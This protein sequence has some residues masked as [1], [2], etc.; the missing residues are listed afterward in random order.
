MIESRFVSVEI[1]TREDARF[2]HRPVHLAIVDWVARSGLSARCVVT[3]GIAGSYEDGAIAA[4]SVEVLASS[5]PVLVTILVPEAALPELLPALEERVS[6]GAIVTRPVALHVLRAHRA[7][8]PP[9]LFV[10]D[11]MTR[12]ALAVPADLPLDQAVTLLLRSRFNALPVVGPDRRPVGILTQG[13][14]IRRAGLPLRIGLL[15]DLEEPRRSAL[16]RDYADQKVAEVMSRPALLVQEGDRLADAVRV[17]NDEGLKRLP[18]VD[19]E[20]RLTGVIARVDVLRAV[21]GAGRA[22]RPP[23]PGDARTVA[24]VTERDLVSVRT[25]T[26]LPLIL[27]LLRDHPAQR[28][29]VV[30]DGGHLVGLIADRDILAALSAHAPSIW[31]LFAR[32]LPLGLTARRHRDLVRHARARVARDLMTER[33]LA[34][35]EDATLDAA[36]ALMLER[37]LKRLP[38]V[39][40]EQRFLGMVSR[41]AIL[42]AGVPQA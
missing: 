7:L 13:D 42:R 14:L 8:L 22:E 32:A 28:V 11:V 20:G 38:V 27:R 29:A 16:L 6:E 33:P 23:A 3:R 9:G 21:A 2:G 1:M 41:G 25:D 35:R 19:A 40:G 15:R 17:M 36:I 37:N 10:R 12:D 39:D 5:L 26:P 31:D 34:V 24:E 18:V 4:S 30:D